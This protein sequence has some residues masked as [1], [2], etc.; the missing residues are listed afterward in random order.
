[1]IA[2]LDAAASKGCDGIDLDNIDRAGHETYISTIFQEAR[3]RGLLVSQKNA[4]EKIDLFW[5]LVDMYQN[6]E[7]Q[8][9]DECEA[10]EDL[11]RPVYNIE[12]S[13]CQAIPYLYSHRKDVEAM[14]AWEEACAL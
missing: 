13:P 12:Y 5:D 2:R 10:Y 9:F 14:D 4:I 11:G 8:Q 3:T 7:C 1:M 6:E